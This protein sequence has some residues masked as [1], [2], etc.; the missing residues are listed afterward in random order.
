V[1]LAD[2]GITKR[3]QG[4]STALY[5]RFDGSF[6]A[7]E[8]L[9]F[10]VDDNAD[11]YTK[12]V[13]MW[14][15]GCLAHWLLT[16]QNAVP[17]QS[18]F[19]FCTGKRPLSM[20]ELR[21]LDTSS[22]AID[23]IASL[24]KADPTERM[25]AFVA[26]NHSWL[27]H[28]SLPAVQTIPDDN[29]PPSLLAQGF[30]ER[31]KTSS[32]ALPF[33]TV[34]DITD[35]ESRGVPKRPPTSSDYLHSRVEDEKDS[36]GS[37]Q[38]R[39][40][41][42]QVETGSQQQSQTLQMTPE[43]QIQNGNQDISST[44]NREMSH[45]K[46][47][48]EPALIGAGIDPASSAERDKSPTSPRPGDYIT[49]PR[50]SNKSGGALFMH[51]DFDDESST[52]EESSV[53]GGYGPIMEEMEAPGLQTPPRSQTQQPQRESS[54]ERRQWEEQLQSNAREP[55]SST[56]SHRPDEDLPSSKSDHYLSLNASKSEEFLRTYGL[57]HDSSLGSGGAL[58]RILKELEGI[59]H[60][61][62]PM[63]SAGPIGD[64]MVRIK[65][66]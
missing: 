36:S 39:D 63:V 56:V 41:A 46:D 22:E 1:K 47:G 13:D 54:S 62:P 15:L 26:L 16:L 42:G 45:S 19:A 18:L 52:T 61:P 50:N 31:L 43:Q 3:V 12:A 49:E 35:E 5:T 30:A 17:R 6:M 10:A 59:K 2:L 64:D 34:E 37:Q 28:A 33:P 65:V 7:P 21:S 24:V 9:G 53:H 29:I 44:A 58:K 11:E 27:R 55:P 57:I 40:I 66:Q 32:T 51:E 20:T 48:S 60:D 4:D 23:Y 25:T 14:A 8:V 38:Q